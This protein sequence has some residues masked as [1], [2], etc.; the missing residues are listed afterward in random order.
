MPELQLIYVSERRKALTGRA[1]HQM[2][3]DA[4]RR[5]EARGISG[6]L[7]IDGRNY[8]QLL[9]G[10]ESAVRSLYAKIESDPRHRNVI[11]LDERPTDQRLFPAW[12]MNLSEVRP[13]GTEDRPELLK[14][15][16]RLRIADVR[17]RSAA[18][19]A[20]FNEFAARPE[21]AV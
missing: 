4:R 2:I 8:F 16:V 11:M 10:E 9:E 14:V 7:L 20:L 5:N 18:A 12:G 1:L 6:M 17:G 15:L 21:L 3:E 19:V 13:V